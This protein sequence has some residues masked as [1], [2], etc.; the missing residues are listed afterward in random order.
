VL[1]K[2]K[3]IKFKQG[4]SN[5]NPKEKVIQYGKLN[6]DDFKK[7]Y[8]SYYSIIFKHT[9]YITGCTQAAEDIT[10]ETFIKYYSSP[11]IH[12][13]VIAWLT[14][15]SSNLS[16][17]YIR[18]E[19]TKQ[20][21]EPDIVE[22][23]FGNVISIED[24]AIRNHEIR[25]TRKILKCLPPRDRMCLLLKFSGYKYTEIAEVI[26]MDF[27]SIGTTLARAQAKFKESYLKEVNTK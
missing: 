4:G 13:N 6:N 11:P 21:K 7:A 3:V 17:N 24:V 19:K 8:E 18:N 26:G 5:I 14:T 25:L 15:V 27:A 22:D 23:G 20:K 2:Y 16:Y 1:Y 9:V 12:S 10:Q